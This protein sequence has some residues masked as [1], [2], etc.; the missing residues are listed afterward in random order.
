MRRTFSSRSRL[1]RKRFRE[2]KAMA[3]EITVPQLGESVIEAV[4]SKWNKKEGEAA[5]VDEPLV[6]LETDKVTVDVPSP[7]AGRLTQIARKEGDKVKVGDVLGSITP[8]PVSASAEAPASA[9]PK[10]APAPIPT[11]APSPAAA[12]PAAP[13]AAAPPPAR[14][15]EV[16]STA[17][18]RALGSPVAR[19]VMEGNSVDASRVRGSGA[20]GRILKE[21]VLQVLEGGA[22]SAS[23]PATIE[24][25]PP[26][27]DGELEERVKMTPLRRRVAERLLAAQ[28]N[29]AILT[30][31]N[32]ID[33]SAVMAL[34]KS[35]QDKFVEKYGVKL[36]L[37]SF[38][39]RASIDALH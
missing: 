38:F 1:S 25:P 28:A 21:D 19:R 22:A 29:A 7:V 11:P 33:M 13:P 4:V 2:G 6:V 15:R 18:R 26:R 34:R 31:F 32:E 8:G 14:L 35:Y 37:M 17:G 5:K 12:P 27:T 3:V 20:G 16:T 36:G 39:V 23:K 10:A 9:P 24:P 30:T